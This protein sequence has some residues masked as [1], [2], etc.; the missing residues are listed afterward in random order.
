MQYS[1]LL[2]TRLLTVLGSS[3]VL[4]AGA[5]VA[6][7]ASNAGDPTYVYVTNTGAD[8]LTRCQLN[9]KGGLEQCSRKL[10][11]KH[12]NRPTD[13]SFQT[14]ADG[15]T[16]LYVV[17]SMSSQLSRCE[18]G[19]GD[20]I[21]NCVKG[22][23][24]GSF[25]KP[26]GFVFHKAADDNTYVYVTNVASSDLT[27]CK[28]DKDGGIG[29]CN[30][31]IIHDSGKLFY[32]PRDTVFRTAADGTTYSYSPNQLDE[33]LTR[34][35]LGKHGQLS[36]CSKGF[37]NGSFDE[38]IALHFHTIDD[39]TYLYVTNSLGNNITRCEFTASGGLK[40]CASGV[41]DGTYYSPQ[42]IAVHKMADGTTYMYIT[43]TRANDLTR[44]EIENNG[45]LTHCVKDFTKGSF[46]LPTG[47][48][49]HKPK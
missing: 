24:G 10:S 44:C 11:S 39:K 18:V 49:F 9:D 42:G 45:D 23:S 43:N 14:V 36:N 47:I 33:D 25:E 38:P 46:K 2:S 17:D 41:S 3:V 37:S 26:T 27:R 40:N 34:C 29:D 7:Y 22:F 6:G 32:F 21:N 13:I 1:R 28:L 19:E 4:F 48:T 8:D 5:G 20:S 12:F 15:T 30:K 35:E 31:D 16:Y